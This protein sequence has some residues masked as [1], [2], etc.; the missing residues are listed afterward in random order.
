MNIF[1]LATLDEAT[2]Y[3]MVRESL[4]RFPDLNR[5]YD[6]EFI[7]RLIPRRRNLD[8]F[9]LLLLVQPDEDYPNT[10][11]TSTVADL[12]LVAAE[13]AWA[14]FKPKFRRHEQFDLQSAKSELSLAA[15]VKGRGVAL[16]LEPRVNGKRACEFMANTSPNTWWEL[17][18]LRDIDVVEQKE[19]VYLEVQNRLRR[20]PQPYILSVEERSRSGPAFL[21]SQTAFLM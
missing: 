3:N 8:N 18:S 12:S 2:A 7:R 19:R 10:F 1:E 4:R 16:T 5:F 9:L 6:D 20:I 14:S 13:G 21:N 15:W 11:W 17:K